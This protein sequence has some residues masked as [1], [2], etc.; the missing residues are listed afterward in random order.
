MTPVALSFGVLR[1]TGKPGDLGVVLAAN[2]VPMLVFMLLGG[3]VAD[4]LPRGRLLVLT[5]VAAALTQAASAAWFLLGDLPLTVLLV[6]TALNGFASAF[7]GPALR[8]IVAELVPSEALEKANAA[9]TTSKNAFRLLGPSA[10]GMLVAFANAGWALAIDTLCLVGAAIL[11]GTLRSTAAVPAGG[12][13]LTSLREGFGEFVSRRWLWS[14]TA[15]FFVVNLALG[16]IWLVLG[17]VVA[18]S[19]IG[20]QGW[21]VVLGVRAAGLVLGGVLAYR[22]QPRRPLM[23]SLLTAL[24]Y[25]AAFAGLGLAPT[26]PV[27]LPLALLAGAGSAIEGVLW[28]STLQKQIRPDVLSRVSSYDMLGSFAS[29]PLGQML[30]APLASVFGIRPTILAGSA[31][32]VLALLAPLL[33]REVLTMGRGEHVA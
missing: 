9:R 10:A 5:H 19:T 6:A 21:G 11:L 2:T 33:V 15:A 18:N 22:F 24:P 16:A 12:S 4:R 7:T 25:A 29:V 17:P 8:G 20:P 31:L 23:W 13:L 32:F 1:A 27:L 3:V 28:E 26:L 30:A 14:I